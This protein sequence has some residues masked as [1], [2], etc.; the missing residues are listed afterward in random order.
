MIKETDTFYLNLDE[1]IQTCM[2]ALR[3]LILKLDS[4]I[5]ETQK[6]GVPCFC[7][8]KKMFCFLSFKQKNKE[9]Y[10][11]VVERWRINHLSLESGGLKRMKHLPIN[12]DEDLPV[13]IIEEVLNEVLDLYRNG[14]IKA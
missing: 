11:L 2:I 3:S 9:P 6:W 1:P 7:Y 4:N 12:A 10:I 8:K 13:A 5:I 14:V